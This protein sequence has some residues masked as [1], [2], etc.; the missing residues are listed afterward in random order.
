MNP[1]TRTDPF[2]QLYARKPHHGDLATSE[3]E[4]AKYT[5]TLRALPRRR[6][7][8]AVAV[9]CSIGTLTERL[10]PACDAL[11]G[12][13][14]VE[15]SPPEA[16]CAAL[17]QRRLARMA[18]PRDWPAGEFDLIIL[19]ELLDFGLLKDLHILAQRCDASAAPSATILVINWLG[20]N[21]GLLSGEAAALTFLQDLGDGW[22]CDNIV[23]TSKYRID[24]ARRVGARV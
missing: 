21:D 13:D 10:A 11:L 24:I 18:I 8:N 16:R 1:S 12:I 3:Y 20:P 23:L 22:A 6:F 4:D 17:P 19:S 5:A 14:P 2:T 7:H 9:G 15:A